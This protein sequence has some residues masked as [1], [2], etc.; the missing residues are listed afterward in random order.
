MSQAVCEAPADGA[1][2]EVVGYVEAMT[3]TA[4]LGWAW[5]PGFSERLS[6]ELRLGDRTVGQ[7]RA[8]GMREDLARSGIGDGRHAFTL[9]I[10]DALRA[11]IGELRVYVVRD[12]S[13]AVALDAPP[14]PA[15]ANADRLLHL[16][17]AVDALIGSQRLMHRNLQAAL[18]QQT[19]SLK[20]A[21]A[22]IASAQAALQ[23]NIATVELFAVRL[24]QALAT[25]EAQVRPTVP[26]RR[27]LIVVT[28]IS[29]LAL[30]SSCWALCRVM[31]G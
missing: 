9:P 21:L 1:R 8:D 7:S 12:G 25:R 11:R 16:Q 28:T 24:E 31:L 22:D 23:E 26:G 13:E 18:L 29:S 4:A 6:V 2:S 14:P 10:P 3:G 19:P 5:C 20:G 27:G 15:D 30:L 17:R